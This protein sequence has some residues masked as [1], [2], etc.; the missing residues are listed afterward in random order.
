MWQPEGGLKKLKVVK[1][2]SSVFHDSVVTYYH[3][4]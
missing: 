4:K 1:Q 3:L 2:N